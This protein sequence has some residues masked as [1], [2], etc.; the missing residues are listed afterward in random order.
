MALTSQVAD[1]QRP[2]TE[3]TFYKLLTV[4]GNQGADP[5]VANHHFHFRPHH[6]HLQPQPQIAGLGR[7]CNRRWDR[8]GPDKM[9]RDTRRHVDHLRRHYQ[10][11]VHCRSTMVM[12]LATG[13]QADRLVGM[14]GWTGRSPGPAWQPGSKILWQLLP[15]DGGGGGRLHG[16]ALPGAWDGAAD[17]V[18]PAPQYHSESLV[19]YH[20]CCDY[21]YSHYHPTRWWH[22]H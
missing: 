18:R 17:G 10:L 11:P 4:P 22:R 5:W 19:K 13:S 2:L 9:G 3:H 14:P 6:H 1:A 16:G 21:W 15:Q 8:W 7:H 12:T 20:Y